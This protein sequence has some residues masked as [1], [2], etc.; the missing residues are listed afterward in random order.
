MLSS[1]RMAW[2]GVKNTHSSLDKQN[3]EPRNALVFSTFCKIVDEEEEDD[4]HEDEIVDEEEEDDKHE[5]E[6][7]EIVD[8]E[9]EDDKHEDEIVDEE[10]E[11]EEEVT[12]DDEICS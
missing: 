10:E 3:F 12:L 2:L 7:D 5:D 11:E 1:T 8:E 4:K 9:E 6:Y